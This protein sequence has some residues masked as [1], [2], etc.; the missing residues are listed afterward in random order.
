MIN[1]HLIA[2]N[3]NALNYLL[4]N[5]KFNIVHLSAQSNDDKVL[6]QLVTTKSILNKLVFWL[7]NIIGKGSLLV[8]VARRS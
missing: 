4:T 6:G 1:H 7:S 5:N 3:K 8:A 2:Y